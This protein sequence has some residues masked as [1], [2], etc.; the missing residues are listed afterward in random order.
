MT[1][2]LL[3]ELMSMSKSASMNL[4][5]RGGCVNAVDVPPPLPEISG[6]RVRIVTASTVGS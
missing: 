4:I 3:D 5:D 1:I 2:P 6:M